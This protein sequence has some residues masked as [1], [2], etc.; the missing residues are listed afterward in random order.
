MS[1]YDVALSMIH[2]LGVARIHHLI[3][4][5]GTAENVFSTSIEQLTEQ[6]KFPH[7]AATY[8]YKQLNRK[9][10]LAQAQAEL[11][12]LNRNNAR[13][14]AIGDDDYPA[15]LRECCD[16]PNVLFVK[17]DLDL[18]SE[19]F[20]S[21]VGTRRYTKYGEELCDN[22]MRE[23]AE[24]VPD[25]VIVSGLAYGI[26]ITAEIAAHKYGL[27]TVSV[28]ANNLREVSPTS[29]LNHL[30]DFIGNGGAVLTE[31]SSLEKT[32]QSSFLRR[33]RI[34][35]GLSSGTL[36]IESHLRGGALST[37]R[38]AMEY[39][40]EVMAIPGR[41]TDVASEG[42]NEL[43]RK[44]GAQLVTNAE[45]IVET[46]GWQHNKKIRSQHEVKQFSIDLSPDERLIYD[47]IGATTAT[48][49]DLIA[50]NTGM[51]IQI[52]SVILVSLEIKNLVKP[53]AGN[54]YIRC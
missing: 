29:H 3:E 46:L 35:A 12:F 34:I 27:R 43:I 40:R 52:V 22:L 50:S 24:L 37:A 4:F 33:N 32:I 17:G 47:A 11:D 54:Q 39:N 44:G 7:E 14:V 49:V 41:A 10:L 28:V 42:C 23:L 48:P 21:V 8:I 38:C 45:Q 1:I 20:L 19:H 16:A 9:D 5:F 2:E 18:N 25:A 53:I 15:M 51:S 36:V 30:R 31:M 26:D 13:A 6:L